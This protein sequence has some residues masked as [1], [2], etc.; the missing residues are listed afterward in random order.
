MVLSAATGAHSSDTIGNCDQRQDK[1]AHAA[2]AA[3]TRSLRHSRMTDFIQ[4]KTSTGTSAKSSMV[5]AVFS[6]VP[7]SALVIEP[8]L[9][10]SSL[11][12]PVQNQGIPYD[13]KQT[14]GIISTQ[15]TAKSEMG[16]YEDEFML[17]MCTLLF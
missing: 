15:V 11:L 16:G 10:E 2:I 5:T 14:N 9:A 13:A 17:C 7:A 12:P 8:N 3:N 4:G 6:A 1:I